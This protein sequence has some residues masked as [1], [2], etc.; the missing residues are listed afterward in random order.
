M[1]KFQSSLLALVLTVATASTAMAS[2][3]VGMVVDQNNNYVNDVYVIV[4][5]STGKRVGD[6]R[7]DFY[8]RY[9]IPVVTPGTYTISFEPGKSGFKGGSTEQKVDV[10]G[11]TVNWFV[12]DIKPADSTS[13]LGVA[14]AAT[15]T[16]GGW[17]WE[18]AAAGGLG[19]LAIG[20][21]VGG[22]IWGET[23]GGSAS[24]SK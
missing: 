5:D 7:T 19:A 18:T 22:V 1:F 16:C 23:G 10:E 11:L 9:C 6:G 20:G 2:G 8:G 15:A 17:Y 21:L 24:P 4:T 12:S 13:D 14:S 3:V